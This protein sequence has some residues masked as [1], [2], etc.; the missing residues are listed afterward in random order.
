M[1]LPANVCTVSVK[2]VTQS[3]VRLVNDDS[4]DDNLSLRPVLVAHTVVKSHFFPFVK[5]M[6]VCVAEAFFA[7]IEVNKHG[8]SD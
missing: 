4:D 6:L 3:Q 8:G 7:F 1:V 5:N 2:S